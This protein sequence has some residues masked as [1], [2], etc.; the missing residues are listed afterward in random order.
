MAG[1]GA[2][3]RAPLSRRPATP[4]R[5]GAGAEVSL[6][7]FDGEHAA[8]RRAPG[9]R[10]QPL[11]RFALDQS[12]TKTYAFSSLGY[13]GEELRLS[14][15]R[16]IFVC[17][18]SVAFG[19][20]LDEDEAWPAR[21]RDTYARAHGLDGGEVNLLNFSAPLAPPDYVV[22]T[23]MLQADRVRPDLIIAE[24]SMFRRIETVRDGRFTSLDVPLAVRLHCTRRSWLRASPR[25]TRVSARDH[26]LAFLQKALL[27][28][29]FCQARGIPFLLLWDRRPREPYSA[30][31]AEPV[32]AP[33][34]A[35][36]DRRSFCAFSVFDADVFVDRSA[37]GI[38]PGPD[39][40]RIIAGRLMEHYAGLT[41]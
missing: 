16:R 20:G 7:A 35:L 33:L 38:H 17:G 40:A 37:D 15:R 11:R 31:L 28:Q 32:F 30:L 23:L 39:S 1:P 5:P 29:S 24:F 9:H 41:P 26:V 12:G 3:R 19:L 25:V 14:A 4:E 10:G 27:L 6:L 21:F 13:R 34:V 2:S 36:L 22:R 18:A 8:A